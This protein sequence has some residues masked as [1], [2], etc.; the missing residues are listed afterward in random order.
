M[1]RHPVA[2]VNLHI[3]YARTMKVDY[4]RFSWG[5]ATWEACSD[6]ILRDMKPSSLADICED[7]GVAVNTFY[8]LDTVSSTLKNDTRWFIEAFI[9]TYRTTW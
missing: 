8:L 5:R 7:L 6:N 2:V 9:H 4:S 3:T 1:G